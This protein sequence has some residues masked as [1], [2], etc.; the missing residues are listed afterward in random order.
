MGSRGPSPEPSHLKLVKGTAATGDLVDEPV[1]DAREIK[2]PSWLTTVARNIW[3]ELAP[4]LEAQG[5]LTP[6][7]R[8]LFARFCALEAINRKAY[9]DVQERGNLVPGD[10]G[11]QV[12]NPSLQILRDTQAQL[13]TLGGRFGLTPSD[14][15]QLKIGDGRK[16]QGRG[17]ERLLD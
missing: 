1:P 16:G 13:T 2:P 9:V 3:K 7:D 10:K 11:R 14:R 4:D 12:K 6:W 15:A 8:H 17:A 5:V